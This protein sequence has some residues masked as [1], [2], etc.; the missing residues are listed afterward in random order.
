M[1]R[2]EH[3]LMATLA[4]ICL[5][6]SVGGVYRAV[7]NCLPSL[8]GQGGACAVALAFGALF[9]TKNYGQRLQTLL[10]ETLPA[11]RATAEEVIPKSRTAQ[12]PI[13]NDD[14]GSL[15]ERVAQL[16]KTVR[17]LETFDA[18][19]K[20]RLNADADGQRLQNMY[21]AF[22]SIVGTIFW[23]FGDVFASWFI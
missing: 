11:L 16:E 6:V 4:F 7:T 5:G 13:K 3:L 19:F 14:V 21:L 8:G 9:L 2:T 23:G 22:S 1:T 12:P 20:Q 18:G 10:T 15:T 17:T